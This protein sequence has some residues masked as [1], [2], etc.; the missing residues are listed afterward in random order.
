MLFRMYAHVIRWVKEFKGG[1]ESVRGNHCA[2]RNVTV[3][4]SYNTDKVKMLL[5]SDRRISCEEMA[6]ELEI[7]VWSVHTIIRNRL[8]MRRR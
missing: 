3:T 2:G 4:D 5:D 1:R 6:Q 7:S 8:R